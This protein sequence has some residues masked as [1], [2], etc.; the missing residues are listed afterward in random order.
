M[1]NSND[2]HTTTTRG[3]SSE[4]KAAAP[5]VNR[6]GEESVRT[7]KTF[8]VSLYPKQREQNLNAALEAAENGFLIFPVVPRK[9]GPRTPITDWQRPATTEKATI[10]SWFRKYPDAL[11]GLLTGER[12][13]VMVLDL[14]KKNGKDGF[15][16]MRKLGHE[17][18]T[19]SGFEVET[20]SGGAHF[21][22]LHEPGPKNTVGKIGPGIDVRTQG[23]YVI[24]PGTT[25]ERGEY[26]I[27]GPLALSDM[28]SDFPLWP[29]GFSI[30]R[31]CRRQYRR[32]DARR[33]L[34]VVE[35]GKARRLRG[36][37]ARTA[38][39]DLL[40][41]GGNTGGRAERRAQQGGHD[42]RRDCGPRAS[43][44]RGS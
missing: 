24:A 12:S 38:G 33:V 1:P 7:P 4:T 31:R 29:E 6:S 39:V 17:P 41:S 20:P 3:A 10:R 35:S 2:N 42:T 19:L 26:R 18:D 16:S 14:D 15:A 28:L 32:C 34:G 44:A 21:Y 40:V 23:G 25:S 37:G 13:G 5:G 27:A 8:T 43:R 11:P 22:F 9:V 30:R 36:M